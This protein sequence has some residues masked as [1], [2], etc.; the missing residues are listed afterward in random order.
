[1]WK[2]IRIRGISHMEKM[3][4][5]KVTQSKMSKLFKNWKKNVVMDW[6][7]VELTEGVNKAQKN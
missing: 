6:G 1:M 4:E 3:N 5:K 7:V 2:N